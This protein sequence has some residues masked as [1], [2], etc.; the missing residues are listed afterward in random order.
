VNVFPRGCQVTDVP[1]TE[2]RPADPPGAD[3]RRPGRGRLVVAALLATLGS[4]AAVLLVLRLMPPGPVDV[5]VPAD[6]LG[7]D[8]AGQPC[9]ALAQALPPTLGGQ[10]RRETVS[11]DPRVAAWGRPSVQLVCGVP[12]P[13]AARFRPAVTVD[14]VSW[15]YRD[16]GDVVEWTTVDRRDVQVLLR[17]P[18]TYTAQEVML[19]D[20]VAPLQGAIEQV[21][22]E[23]NLPTTEG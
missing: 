15:D 19:Q 10:E 11:G 14:G 8:V 7:Q 22:L 20:L 3:R 18:T 2:T 6:A 9:D 21:P 1:V 13:G 5:A 23:V 4:L 16:A 12:V 17:V